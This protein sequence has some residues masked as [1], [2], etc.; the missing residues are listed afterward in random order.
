MESKNYYDI[1]GVSEKA[2]LEDITAAKNEL[3]KKYHPDVNL[4][5]GIDTTEQ[6]QEILEAYRVLSN[7]DK[8]SEYDWEIRRKRPVMQTFDLHNMEETHN[9]TTPEF[10]SYWKAANDLYDIVK[11]S[12]PLFKDRSRADELTQ[13]STQAAEHV[14]LLRN[15]SIPERY[16]YPDIMNWLLFTWFQHRNY[17]ISYLLTLYD[18]YAKEN[19]SALDKLKLQKNSYQYQHSIKRLVKI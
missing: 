7:P 14:L 3:A 5:D 18:E 17:T 11:D 8:R 10:V 1:L 9:E 16:W 12:D 15:A 19:I 4:K 13:L 6:M 2:S